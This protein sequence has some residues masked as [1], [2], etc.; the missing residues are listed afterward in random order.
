MD[1]GIRRR[2]LRNSAL[3]G[4]FAAPLIW[5]IYFH[6]LTVGD[7]RSF[8]P[9][10]PDQLASMSL[11]VVLLPLLV[12][13]S[14]FYVAS[15][16]GAAF[17]GAFSELLVGSLY[18]AGFAVF[19]ALF[20]I[21]SPGSEMLNSAGYLFLTAFA[22]LL[23]YNLLATLSRMW[24]VHA[25][26]ALA[27]S[28][29]IYVEG[30]VALML[31]DLFLGSS[32]LSLPGDLGGALTELLDLGFM[33]ATAVSL[34]GVLKT[35]R[36]PYLSTVGGIASNYLLVVSASLIG[37]L[38]FNY[39]RGR[40]ASISP[41]IANLSP[42]IEW[43]AICIVAAI[44]F[45]RTR[46]GMQASMMAEARLGDW[47]KHVQEVSTYKGDRFVG[48]TET[49]NDFIERGR[50]DRLLINLTM[51]LHDNRVEHG[52]IALLLSDL[53]NYED[54]K[55]PFFS[56]RG[57]VTALEKENEARR[58]S[59][60]KRTISGILPLGLGGSAKGKGPEPGVVDGPTGGSDAG[61][62]E[63][64]PGIGSNINMLRMEGARDEG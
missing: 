13:V 29:T 60:L 61:S 35:S 63:E 20:L 21:Y 43:T 56:L 28:A 33:V 52:E 2:V 64:A 41:G 32:G 62:K 25:L 47:I 30:Y 36:N 6:D 50:R 22:V 3:Y 54:A 4:V 45:T 10:L 9:Y 48:F 51:F 44:V 15:L 11:S 31:L 18:A 59:V 1:R 23:A 8:L 38:Y 5:L 19:F 34:F 16:F 12:S 53:I 37:S 42:Y 14:I 27:A 46:K 39:F 40:L 58:R 49:I 26:R 7:F 55:K 24:K 17:E 57:R